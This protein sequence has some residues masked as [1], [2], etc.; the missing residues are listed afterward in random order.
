MTN[1][2]LKLLL[3]LVCGIFWTI[4]YIDI[5][6]I[7]IKDQTYGMPFLALSLNFSW[8]IYNTV[9]GYLFVGLHV[10]N[11]INFFWVL[12]DMGILYTYFR[13]GNKILNL[14]KSAF[15]IVSLSILTVSFIFQ[16]LIGIRLGLV[17]GALYSAFGSN[18]L[19][20]LLFI[21]MFFKRTKGNGQTLLIAVAKCVGTLSITVLV[22]II[23]INQLGGKIPEIALIGF[24]VFLID[25]WYIYLVARANSKRLTI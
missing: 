10:A 6:R 13:Y 2:E 23:G 3:L 9:Q 14:K 22:G 25:V 17:T 4:A 1:Y 19:M 7:G 12:F 15:Y 24:T 18:L 20:S 11:I 5:I 8:E 21:L 16:H